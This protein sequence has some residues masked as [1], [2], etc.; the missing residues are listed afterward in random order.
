MLDHLDHLDHLDCRDAFEDEVGTL[1][2]QGR[3]TWRTTVFDG[4]DQ[5]PAALAAVLAGTTT[6]KGIVRV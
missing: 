4:L 5:A 6:G 3:L 2:A 1:L